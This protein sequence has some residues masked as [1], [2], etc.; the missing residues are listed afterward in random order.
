[1]NRMFVSGFAALAVVLSI[2]LLG[3]CC[4]LRCH[5]ALVCTPAAA[6]CK[7]PVDVSASGLRHRL[8]S[9]LRSV[10]QVPRSPGGCVPRLLIAASG[11][12]GLRP[13]ACEPACSPLA[14]RAG[15]RRC[16][17][18][19]KFRGH[20][21]GAVPRLLILHRRPASRLASPLAIR[22]CGSSLR[23]V[24]KSRGLTAAV[25]PGGRLLCEAP[26]ACTAWGRAALGARGGRFAPA[27][28][29]LPLL[30]LPGCPGCPG[31]SRS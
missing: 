7:A 16:G 23:S 26:E 21:G 1:M 29:L 13:A 4:H 31:C 6:V 3:G 14:T 24:G 17:L 5:S 19:S 10:R 20:R 15:G 28:R 22:G 12:R 25:R 27:A 11:S 8:W 9:S 2:A 18:F 30:R